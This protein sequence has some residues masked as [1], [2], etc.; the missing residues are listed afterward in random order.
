MGHLLEK[1]FRVTP[2]PIMIDGK[3]V[4]KKQKI[5]TTSRT[6]PE[7]LREHLEAEEVFIDHGCGTQTDPYVYYYIIKGNGAKVFVENL[8]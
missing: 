4:K 6:I 5:F 7:V 3:T 1:T 8:Y 2:T